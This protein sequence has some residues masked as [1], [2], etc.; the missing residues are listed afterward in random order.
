MFW[1]LLL[2]NFYN[3]TVLGKIRTKSGKEIRTRSD[4]FQ[5]HFFMPLSH[6]WIA[7]LSV[8]YRFLI[9]VHSSAV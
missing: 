6:I 8:V 1:F 3:K 4:W 9:V 5:G 7:I 2:F